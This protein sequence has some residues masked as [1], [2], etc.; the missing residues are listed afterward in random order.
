MVP[1]VA[2]MYVTLE[3][4]YAIRRKSPGWALHFTCFSS[5]VF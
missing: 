2:I 3:E 5:K 1:V 4:P